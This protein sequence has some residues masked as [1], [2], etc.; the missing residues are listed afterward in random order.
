MRQNTDTNPQLQDRF[1]TGVIRLAMMAIM[2]IGLTACA[3][4]EERL[5]DIGKPPALNPIENPTLQPEYREVSMPMPA[6]VASSGEANSLWNSQRK[7]FF[8]DQ[9]ASDVGDIV[10]VEINM[11]DSAQLNNKTERKRDDSE[12][13]DITGL[14]GLETQLTKVLPEGVT[15]DDL[16]NLATSHDTMGEGKITRDETIDLKV[17][18]LVVQKLPNGNMVIHGRQEVRVNFEKRDLQVAGVIRPEDIATDNTITYD[19]IAEAR[20]AY[21]GKGQITDL[22]QPRYGLQALDIL[23]P[24]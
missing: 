2:L 16:N 15:G 1:L 22:Q 7:S 12:D 5:A 18:A 11:A 10:T 21:G 20:I 17:A 9:R 14:L 4:I 6:Y 19:K 3:N 23:M 13:L 24:F 8:K